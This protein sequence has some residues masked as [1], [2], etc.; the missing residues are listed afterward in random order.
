M[1][2]FWELSKKCHNINYIELL[3]ALLTLKEFAN[4]EKFEGSLGMWNITKIGQYYSDFI[5]KLNGKY[6]VALNEIP[7]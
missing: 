7:K 4:E 2:G 5:H 1:Y 3:I 6:Q